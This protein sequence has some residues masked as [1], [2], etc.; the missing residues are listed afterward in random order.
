MR[1]AAPHTHLH[2]FL[3]LVSRQLAAQ[4]EVFHVKPTVAVSVNDLEQPCDL[5]QALVVQED[6]V[7]QG[8]VFVFTLQTLHDTITCTHATACTQACMHDV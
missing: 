6:A 4:F 3:P 2:P 1:H 7:D 5:C 8:G